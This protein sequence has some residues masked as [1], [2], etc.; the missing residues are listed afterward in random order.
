MHGCPA[1]RSPAPLADLVSGV[2]PAG[3]LLLQITAAISL[4]DAPALCFE[5]SRLSP[6]SIA[7]DRAKAAIPGK[8]QR[9]ASIPYTLV[10]DGRSRAICQSIDA[11]QSNLLD[12][13]SPC[14]LDHM[15]TDHTSNWA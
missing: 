5:R 1:S 2:P 7:Q 14:P 4:G 13:S 12:I 11:P 3:R 6:T 10:T 8:H 9:G 15:W